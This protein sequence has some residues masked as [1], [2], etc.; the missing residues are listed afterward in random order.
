MKSVFKS[1]DLGL[2][3]VAPSADV[4]QKAR[5]YHAKA[6]REAVESGA[7]IREQLETYLRKNKMWDDARQAE[8]ERLRRSI[9]AN[10]RRLAGGGIKLSE[11][12]QVALDMKRYREELQELLSQRNRI[13]VNTADAIAEQAQFNYLVSACTVYNEGPKEGRPYFTKDGLNY[14]VDDY[15]EKG[16]EQVAF[17][18]A[19]ELS[20]LMY[21]HESDILGQLPENEFLKKYKF[22]D[23]E[24]HLIDKQGRRVDE[25][26]RL[27]DEE[28][29][30]IDE[31]GNR[32]DSE[33]NRVDEQGKY[34]VEFSPF[35]DDEGNPL[36][37][38]EDEVV[39]PPTLNEEVDDHV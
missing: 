14:S 19:S 37:E 8:Y 38:D 27:V 16:T 9:L 1:G 3:I 7:M 13:D 26:G 12:R 39:V 5:L 20:K 36:L 30:F 22:V 15:I 35:L 18:A 28:G 11:A 29:Y 23:E 24:F 32:V 25:Q 2:A 4:K 6:F 21:G 33:G 31:E 34:I 17:D 10:E